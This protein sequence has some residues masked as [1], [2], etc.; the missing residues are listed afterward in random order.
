MRIFI[1][2]GLVLLLGCNP[3]IDFP[4][5][6]LKIATAN[7]LI[8]NSKNIESDLLEE[9]CDIYLLHEAAIGVNL[10][11][12]P[13]KEKGYRVFSHSGSSNNAF[14]G[15]L[16][17]RLDG[18]FKPV[19]LGYGTTSYIEPF[20]SFSFVRAGRELLVIGVHIPP[21]IFMF[22]ELEKQRERAIRDITE[23][24]NNGR[25]SMGREVILAG[26][27]NTHP[28]DKL[29]NYILNSSLDDAILFNKNRYDN[30]W[31]PSLSPVNLARIDYIFVSKNL[32]TR[33]LDSFNI[34]GSDH[35][36]LVVGVDL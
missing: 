11:S 34:E 21:N 5:T 9:D 17:T 1:Y 20:Y 33:Y 3:N 32:D 4:D 12:E 8:N 18:E 15:V 16:I 36:G 24:I 14:N 2:I 23:D 27:F 19:N 22:P 6:D 13:F 7:I 25:D 35:R 28:S 31:G 10:R 29:L 30:T 26:D